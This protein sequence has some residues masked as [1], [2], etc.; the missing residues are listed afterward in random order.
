MKTYSVD[1]R[2][3]AVSALSK[4]HSPAQVQE[5]FGVSRSS[6]ERWRACVAQ[7]KSLAPRPRQ[8]RPRRVRPEDEAA[9]R[10]Q[11]EAHPDATL[12]EHL[13]MWRSQGHS[14]SR[15]TIDRAIKALGIT[16]KKSV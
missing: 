9:L 2:E 5:M 7:G 3:R 8:G 15:A 12:E 6:L 14:L 13:A 10:A 11:V 16:H 1:L 4:G